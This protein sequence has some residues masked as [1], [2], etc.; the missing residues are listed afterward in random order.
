M[1]WKVFGG[2][3]HELCLAL[4][5]QRLKRDGLALTDANLQN[6]FRLHL[7][8]GLGYLAANRAVRSIEGL[9]S[10]PAA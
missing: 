7:H 5:K 4:L 9:A 6:Q 10:T 1:A 8:R 3:H 2:T